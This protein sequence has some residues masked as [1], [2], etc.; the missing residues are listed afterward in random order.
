[1]DQIKLVVFTLGGSRYTRPAHGLGSC[2]FY[3]KAWQLS[4]I[5]VG[6][7]P[8]TAFLDCNPNWT[9]QECSR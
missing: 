3:P 7:S 5:K 2:G 1:M 6:Q 4:P 9:K 8:I